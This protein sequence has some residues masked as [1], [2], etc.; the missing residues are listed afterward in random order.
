MDHPERPAED[1]GRNN[2]SSHSESTALFRMEF[3]R[4]LSDWLASRRNESTTGR[5]LDFGCADLLLARRLDGIWIVDGYDEWASARDAAR[6]Q[7]RNLRSPGTVHDRLEDVPRQAYDAVVLNSLFQYVPDADS[8]RQLF[9][10]VAPLL[11]RDA[12]IGIVITDA[13]SDGAS[14]ATDLRDLVRYAVHTSGLLGGMTGT[15][16]GIRSGKPARRHRIPEAEL[17]DAARAVGL[18]L[19]R[20]A[21]N[22]SVFSR[23]ATFVLRPLDDQGTAD[24]SEARG[25]PT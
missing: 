9:A 22:L 15:V 7:L 25:R 4:K 16:R 2:P 19:T 1:E 10:D 14:P 23:R 8:A 18:G 5:L 13:V 20:H 21:E 12:P 6:R 17:A 11:A 3:S 24:P